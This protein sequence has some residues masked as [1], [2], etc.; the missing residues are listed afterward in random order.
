MPRT[1]A[2]ILSDFE[3][4]FR[5]EVICS[6]CGRTGSYRVASV[7]ARKGD[8][9]LTDFVNDV[10]ADCPK[11]NNTVSMI[12]GA[13]GSRTWRR[14]GNRRSCDGGEGK[15]SNLRNGLTHLPRM[16]AAP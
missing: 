16:G 11:H 8:V 7:M 2:Q 15:D 9:R 6:K 3:P 13:P 1:G 10:S 12:G 5:I 14:G 4:D